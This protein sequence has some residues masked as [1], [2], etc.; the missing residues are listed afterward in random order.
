M[1]K[2][3]KIIGIILAASALLPAGVG[4]ALYQWIGQDGF[5]ERAA[6]Q[7][8][9]AMGVPVRLGAIRIDWFPV[10]S[11]AL[12]DVLVETKPPL[13][14]KRI[15]VRPVWAALLQQRLEVATLVVRGAVVPQAG[16][17]ALLA[18]GQRK[19]AAAGPSTQQPVP[20]NEE[21]AAVSAGALLWVPHRTLIDGL[22]WTSNKGVTTVLDAQ[23][24]LGDD[25]LPQQMNVQ[26]RMGPYEGAKAGVMREGKDWLVDIAVGGGTVKGKVSFRASGEPGRGLV[27]SGTLD[28]R[29]VEVSAL[30][31]PSRPLTGKVNAATS[32]NAR[33]VSATGLVDALQT[34]TRFTVNNAVLQGLDLVKAVS[35]MGLSRGGETALSELSGQVLTQ[36]RAGRLNNLV[37][38]SGV[39]AARGDVAVSPAQALSGRVVVDVTAGVAS[40]V[41]GI[42][43]VVG[44]TVNAPEVSLSRSAM[45]GAAL[46]TA[47]MPGVGTGA[48]AKLGDS[49]GQGLSGLFGGKK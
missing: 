49:I 17:E 1:R 22:S 14:V 25:G 39:L 7:A 33:A 9:L 42:P 6:Q 47:V 38:R 37:A 40:G 4:F 29:N 12:D 43:L 15:E 18:A 26:V 23:A 20:G 34:E 30:T 46:G 8:T 24:Q 5:R 28:T 31:A 13:S 19:K 27:M 48:G 16:V 21:A 41:T 45:L 32:F 11:V 2:I 10:P 36:G 35:T 44:G 3:F